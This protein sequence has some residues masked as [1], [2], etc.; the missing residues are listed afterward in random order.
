MVLS[1]CS[2]VSCIEGGV[3]LIASGRSLVADQYLPSGDVLEV[4]LQLL[5]VSVFSIVLLK[6]AMF[7]IRIR[8][9]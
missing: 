6:L 8:Q 3:D 5:G 7:G 4:F 1:K 9:L 2:V